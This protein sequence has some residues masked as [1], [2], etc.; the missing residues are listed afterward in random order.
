[1]GKT[2]KIFAFLVTVLM[3]SISVRSQENPISLPDFESWTK[4][5]LVS[6]DFNDDQRMDL[7]ITM[8]VDP[9]S[10]E[11]NQ[12]VV[13]IWEAP[14]GNFSYLVYMSYD[15]RSKKDLFISYWQKKDGKWINVPNTEFEKKFADYLRT[16]GIIEDF[17]KNLMK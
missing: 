13:Q 14:T 7:Y 4:M 8:Y 5:E 17:L 2:V 16:T 11:K 1:M 6:V 3:L 10:D 9:T 15:N 12:R